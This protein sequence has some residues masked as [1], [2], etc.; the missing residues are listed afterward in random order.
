MRSRGTEKVVIVSGT[1]PKYISTPPK[2]ESQPSVDVKTPE[3]VDTR[4]NADGTMYPCRWLCEYGGGRYVA[5]V[6]YHTEV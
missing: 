3:T 1:T 2:V 4:D 5:R 6:S